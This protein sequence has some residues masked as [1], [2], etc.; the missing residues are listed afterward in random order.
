MKKEYLRKVKK[1]VLT[2]FLAVVV[3]VMSS[4][5][6]T[7]DVLDQA[8]NIAQAED[9][10]VLGVKGGTSTAYP[11]K[12]FGE[13]F[14]SF[15]TAPTWKYFV[16]TKE[17]TDEDGDGKPD[18]TEENVGVVEFTGYCTYQDVE[19]KA[20]VQFTLSGDGETFEASYLSFN[21][22][23]QN[24]LMLSA[25][26]E[27][28]FTDSDVEAQQQGTAGASPDSGTGEGSPSEGGAPWEAAASNE[29][30]EASAISGSYGGT[31][32][33]STLSVSIY[34]SPE[35]GEAGIGNAEIYVEGGQYSYHGQIAELTT[36]VYKVATDTG[37]EV[38]LAASKADD[39][40]ITVA[41]YVDG[42]LVEEYLMMEHYES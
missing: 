16:G 17:G 32:G 19:V 40:T 41:L 13:A 4:G 35:E 30:I 37:E 25:L 6:G 31:M 22:V 1:N 42:Q 14:D 24:M 18:S 7:D 10:H 39:G 11:G 27:A 2:V 33:Q 12:T 21:E 3:A 38:L 29:R 5:C 26:M 9:E 23:P 8:A 36:N 34:S 15:F 28:A 20:L